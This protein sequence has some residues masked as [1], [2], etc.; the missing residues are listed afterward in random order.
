M[1]VNSTE[2]EKSLISFIKKTNQDSIEDFFGGD[3]YRVFWCYDVEKHEMIYTE[4]LEN[5]YG[6]SFKEFTEQNL[7]N[8]VFTDKGNIEAKIEDAFEKAQP[9]SL[10]YEIIR[11]DGSAGWVITKGRPIKTADN[12][13]AYFHGVTREITEKKFSEIEMAESKNKYQTLV[14]NYAHG[15]YISNGKFQYVNQRLVD[16]TGYSEKELL[17]MD[18]MELLDEESKNLVKKRSENFRNGIGNEKNIIISIIRKNKKK[19]T[20]ELRSSIIKYNDKHA[21]IGTIHDITEKKKAQE[22]MNN[23]AYY[24]QLT[25]IPNRNS[26]YKTVTKQL[27]KGKYSD[28]LALLFID[29]DQFKIIND[30]FGHQAGDKLIK[31]AAIK[32]NEIVGKKGFLA[33]YGGDEFVITMKYAEIEQVKELSKKLIKDVPLSLTSEIKTTLSIGISLFPEHGKEIGTLLRYADIAMYHTKRD[34]N[35][36]LNY[37]IYNNLLSSKTARINKL[38]SSFKKAIDEAQFSLVYQPKVELKTNKLIGIE[39]LIRWEHPELGNISPAEF[40]PLAEK[41]GYINAI[42]DWVL[43]KAINDVKQLDRNIILNV[44][45]SSRQLLEDS[46]IVKIQQVLEATQYPSEY[47]NL[48]ITESVAILDVEMTIKIL[49]ELKKTGVNISLDDFGTGYSSL[50]YLTRLPID[51]LKIDKSFL[52]EIEIEESKEAIIKS[53]ITVAH[54]LNMKVIAEG[55]ETEQQLDILRSLDCDEGQGYL[56]SRPVPLEEIRK[57]M[58]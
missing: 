27:K 21:T 47:L 24:D 15:I 7:W 33:R 28:K 40:I 50:S 6:Y 42:G 25:G 44:N 11:K 19:I 29:L 14:E 4:G 48:E 43:N 58:R 37:S 23:L 56:F 18:Y 55:I 26:F 10:E 9:F 31:E 1:K 36:K 49:N 41:N 5:I 39:A 30:T 46:F 32:M 2:E 17:E 13:L 38:L 8:K 3:I 57:F 53:I 20:A 35:R 22:M 16:M 34:E 45:I 54:N 51:C 12:K 52:Y